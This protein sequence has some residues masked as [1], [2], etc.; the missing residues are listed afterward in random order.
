MK[1]SSPA[2]IEMTRNS[3]RK[4]I[5]AH[6]NA[7]APDGYGDTDIDEMTASA[8]SEVERVVERYGADTALPRQTGAH[9]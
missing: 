9:E 2:I 4:A 7:I 3:L 5:W 1:S 6:I 8:M